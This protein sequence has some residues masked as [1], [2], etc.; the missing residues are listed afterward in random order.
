MK[1]YSQHLKDF[2]IVPAKQQCFTCQEVEIVSVFRIGK[3]YSFVIFLVWLFLELFQNKA[4]IWNSKHYFNLQCI[5][6]YQKLGGYV[7]ES[8]VLYTPSH[9][10]L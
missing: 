1:G 5:S 6:P 4:N 7:R 10:L 9:T 2:L 3:I 8:T